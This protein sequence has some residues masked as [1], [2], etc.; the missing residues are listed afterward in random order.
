MKIISRQIY[1]DHILRFLNKGMMIALT[2]QRRVGKSYVLRELAEIIRQNNPDANIIYINKE[3]KKY[4]SIKTDSDLSAYI[5]GKFPEDEDN[6]LL[7]DEVQDIEGFENT[8]RSLNAD[9]ECQIIVTG[10]NAKML[11]S[12]LSTYLGGRYIDIHIQSLSYREFLRFHNLEDSAESLGKYLSFGGLPHL[13]RLG[14]EN[15][16]MVWEYVQNIYNTIVLKDVVQREGLR[17][18]TLFENLMSYVSDNTGQLVSATSLSKY[19]KAQRVELT[20]LTAVNYLKAASNA[21]IIDKVKRYDIHGK[22]LLETNDKYYFEDLGLRN[23]LV[24]SNRAKDIEKVMENAVYLHLKNLGYKV[25]VGT[26]P[27]GE[28]DFVAEKGGKPIYIQVAYLL[29]EDST[30]KREFGNLIQ[31]P[32]NYPKYVVSMDPITKPKDYDGI[33]QM[34]LRTFLLTDSF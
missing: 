32:D 3:K 22:R 13:Y 30:V 9:D 11:S 12:E 28:I 34:P 16:D 26:L 2:G 1:I 31:I 8:L 7:I 29:N 33:T 6:Y 14:I 25:A 19:L 17:N 15:E 24:G 27:N 5:E 23:L 20:P 21:Y 10:S 4:D 18:V